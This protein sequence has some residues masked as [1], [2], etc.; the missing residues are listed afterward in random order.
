MSAVDSIHLENVTAFHA[1]SLDFSPGV[2]ILIGANGTGK[3]HLLKLMYAAC[4]ITMGEDRERTFGVKL[5]DVFKP[6]E[7][8]IGRLA[9]RTVGNASALIQLQG[10]GCV[11]EAS[12]SRRATEPAVRNEK[13]WKGRE[14]SSAYIPV[15]EM[16]VHAP[17]FMALM[18]AREVAFEAVY[19]DIVQRALVPPLRGAYGPRRASLFGVLEQAIDGRVT[20]KGEYFFLKNGQGELEFS[21]LSEGMRKLSLLLLL[22]QNGTL[23]RDEPSLSGESVLFWDEPEANLNPAIMGLVVEVLLELQRM[24]VQIFLATHSYVLLKE[25]DLRTKAEDR[26]RYIS[27]FRDADRQVAASG[28]DTYVGIDHS[29]IADTFDNLYERDIRRALSGETR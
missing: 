11:L 19:S 9:I 6:Y 4:A 24:G 3:T 22:V 17:G 1:L 29:A 16:L 13:E 23:V 28:S 8:R 14:L 12:F 18:A 7:G 27:L 5:R 10:G 26:V 21:L 20:V 2:N 25:F 15:K